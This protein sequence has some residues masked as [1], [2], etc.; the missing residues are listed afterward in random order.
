MRPFRLL[1]ISNETVESDVLHEAI[2]GL[3]GERDADVTV[4][5]PALNSR[6]RHWCSDEDGARH[7]AQARLERC[8]DRLGQ[9]GITAAGWVGDADPM[10]A[11]EDALRGGDV[12]ELLV[13]THPEGRSNWLAHD[14]VERAVVRFGL[15][16]AHL[17]VTGD[18]EL[19][20][21]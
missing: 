15:P 12:D 17:V 10:L 11:I 8:L 2:V 19:I 14:L 4:V 20:A 5:A 9:H 18:R 16:T 1:V 21:A 3:A 7:A 13:A 6:F